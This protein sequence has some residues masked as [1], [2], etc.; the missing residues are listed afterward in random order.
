MEQDLIARG[1]ILPTFNWPM[2][3]KYFFYAHGGTFR[4]GRGPIF[5]EVGINSIGGVSMLA[6]WLSNQTWFK[7]LQSLHRY[8]VGYQPRTTWLTLPR[9][10][11]LQANRRT[12]ARK[13]KHAIWNCRCVWSEQ[14]DG[15]QALVIKGLIA[16]VVKNKN[17]ALI[18]SKRTCHHSY[19]KE[20]CFSMENLI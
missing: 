12:Q 18:H 17:G 15:V 13:G 8:S 4:W 11:F 6:I 10:F 20:D 5:R 1:I 9:R 14:Q 3:E 19:N 16:T 2:R 7:V